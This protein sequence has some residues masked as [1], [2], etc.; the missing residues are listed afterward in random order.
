M[1][2]LLFGP[3]NIYKI[4]SKVHKKLWYFNF[5]VIK[6]LLNSIIYWYLNT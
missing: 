3:N 2:K 4:V 1:I 6:I 5:E